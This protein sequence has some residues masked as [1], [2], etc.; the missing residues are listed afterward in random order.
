M[1]RQRGVRGVCC[2]IA[3]YLLPVI[4]YRKPSIAAVYFPNLFREPKFISHGTTPLITE[5]LSWKLLWKEC[6]PHAYLAGGEF[7]SQEV[8]SII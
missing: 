4:A 7:E 2:V 1:R 8:N 3:Y 6:D 5:F